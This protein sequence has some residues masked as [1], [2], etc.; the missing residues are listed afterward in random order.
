MYDV[1]PKYMLIMHSGIIETLCTS[2]VRNLFKGLMRGLSR[3]YM[4]LNLD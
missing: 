2:D 1:G 3:V 4:G